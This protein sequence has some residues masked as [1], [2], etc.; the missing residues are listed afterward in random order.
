MQR[1]VSYRNTDAFMGG[2]RHLLV[3]THHGWKAEFMVYRDPAK[4][5]AKLCALRLQGYLVARTESLQALREAVNSAR[6]GT[7]R[8]DA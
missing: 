7:K 4:A 2:K 3:V 8:T 1:T 5:F 6:N